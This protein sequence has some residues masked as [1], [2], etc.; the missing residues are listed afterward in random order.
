MLYRKF[1]VGTIVRTIVLVKLVWQACL[2]PYLSLVIKLFGTVPLNR[3][4]NPI[5][6][7]ILFCNDF[8][9]AVLLY[10]CPHATVHH[11]SAFPF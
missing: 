7:P 5:L 9:I 1:T 8:R 3:L 10:S 2:T 6:K 11:P 4:I